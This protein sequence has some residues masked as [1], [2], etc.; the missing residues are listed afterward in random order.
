MRRLLILAAAAAA[1][2]ACSPQKP[3]APKAQATPVKYNTDIPMNEI[4]GDIIDP[5]AWTYWRAS[6]TEVTAKG[7]RDLSPTKDD[8]WIP[9]ENA[10]GVLVEAGNLLQLPGRARPPEAE[11]NRYAQ[12]LTERAMAARVAAEKHDKKGVF[13][14]GG[15]VY[16]VCTA[17]HEKYVIQPELKS[18]GGAPAAALPALPADVANKAAKP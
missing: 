14:E 2:A 3:A 4:M 17:C 12:Q 6:G 18:E 9:V 16:E 7:E 1:L 10:A 15:R 8:D 5:A 11:W 13:D